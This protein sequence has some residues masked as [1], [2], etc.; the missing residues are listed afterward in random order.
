MSALRIQ[1]RR[2][3]ASI[4][5]LCA[6]LVL[7]ACG[8][9]D[10]GGTEGGEE[11]KT[12]VYYSTR[13]EEGLPPLKAAFEKANPGYKLDII[14]ASS[15]DTVARLLTEAQARRQQAD[16]TELNALPM[17][18]LEEAGILGTLPD[19]VLSKLPDQAK[20]A[21]GTYAG[22]RYFGHLTPF[23]TKIVPAAEQPKSYED[24]LK[25][26]WKGKFVVGAN[27]V[28]WAYQVYES[29]GDQEGRKFLE[30]IAA[31]RPQVRDEGRGA[32]AELVA[33]GQIPAAIM[34]LSYH[35]EN[36]KKE[37]LPIDGAEWNPPLL[38]IDWIATFKD[39]PHPESTKIF[40]DWLYSDDGIATD[41]KI[42]FARIGDEGTEKALGQPGLII[43]TPTTA[44]EQQAAADAF[45]EVFGIGG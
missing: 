5:V 4:S 18:Q 36:R 28:E 27:D 23:N 34:T 7:A 3:L 8:G 43:L 12:I 41:A 14:R 21:D 39:A 38:N 35:V 30:A 22:T 6:L 1:L 40:L 26:Y 33:V 42:G 44:D 37:G 32:L 29:K 45:E 20:S 11:E 25:P 31:Q 2:I 17:A 16:V 15:S 13:P 19:S 9:G 24:L 10:E